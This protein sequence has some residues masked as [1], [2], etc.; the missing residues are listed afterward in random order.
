MTK[1]TS[2]EAKAKADK[3]LAAI[4]NVGFATFGV[5]GWPDQRMLA[6]VTRSGV[7]EIW[8]ATSTDARKIEELKANSKASIYGVNEADMAE[9]RLFGHVELH[10]DA[11]SRRKAWRDDFIEH[12]PDGVDSPNL[13]A[14]RFITKSGEFATYINNENG[15]F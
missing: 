3:I 5:N 10:T 13:I 15:S 8:F 11:E 14:L 9:I 12:F 6:V 2:I 1:L 7:D 4:P